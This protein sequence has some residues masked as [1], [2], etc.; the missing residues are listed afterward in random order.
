MRSF[1]TDNLICNQAYYLMK[2]HLHRLIT[3]TD[4]CFCFNIR[5]ESRDIT[6]QPHVQACRLHNVDHRM[7]IIMPT[8]YSGHEFVKI[9]EIMAKY[10]IYKSF[11]HVLNKAQNL[12]KRQVFLVKIVQ[13]SLEYWFECWRELATNPFAMATITVRYVRVD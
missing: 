11:S 12:W 8:S 7:S 6:R 5:Q 2:I 1:H 13:S 9:Q 4:F 10:G 3:K